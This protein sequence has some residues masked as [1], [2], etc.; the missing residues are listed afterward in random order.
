MYIYV[1]KITYIYIYIY[2]LKDRF[3]A[4]VE[5]PE[6][7]GP[8]VCSPKTAK[9]LILWLHSAEVCLAKLDNMRKYHRQSL[10]NTLKPTL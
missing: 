6:L 8:E 1:Y 2:I 4:Q 7:V 10:K 9:T 3:S 5:V